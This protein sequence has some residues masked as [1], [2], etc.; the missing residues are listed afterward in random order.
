MKEDT[1]E[2]KQMTRAEVEKLNAMLPEGKKW[3]RVTQVQANAYQAAIENKE[4]MEH[5]VAVA[6]RPPAFNRK[7]RRILAAQKRKRK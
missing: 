2:V 5:D 6:A 7:Q 1:G 3:I 4:M